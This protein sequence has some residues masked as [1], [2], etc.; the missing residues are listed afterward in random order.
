MFRRY[1]LMLVMLAVLGAG[2]YAGYY[3]IWGDAGKNETALSFVPSE[4]CIVVTGED[5]FELRQHL[6]NSSLLWQD[7]R[8]SGSE[9]LSPGFLDLGCGVHDKKN[10]T[11]P[12]A[13][14]L[15]G[16][17]R[18]NVGCLLAVVTSEPNVEVWMERWKKLN[19]SVQWKDDE[20]TSFTIQSDDNIYA[21]SIQEN[22][23][24]FSTS[25]ALLEN[26]IAQHKKGTPVTSEPGFK[27]ISAT[28]EEDAQVN[29]YFRHRT[30]LAL[31]GPLLYND[32]LSSP[33]S[34][35]DLEKSFWDVQVEPDAV[36]LNGFIFSGNEMNSALDIM[37]HQKPVE[38]R[39]LKWL[40]E[41]T[42]EF[43][44]M[45]FSS[46]AKFLDN[47]Q[48]VSGRQRVKTQ[49]DE[50]NQQYECNLER[51]LL[52]WL[53]NELM[54]FNTGD[55][56][57]LLIMEVDEVS[58]PQEELNFLS[59]QLDSTGGQNISVNN[60]VIRRLDADDIFVPLL[61]SFFSTMDQPY[62][63][64]IDN[65][66]IF[67]TSV[68][69]LTNYMN[70]ISN[71][72]RYIRNAM[73][74]DDLHHYFSSACNLLYH[75]SNTRTSKWSQWFNPFFMPLEELFPVSANITSVTCQV[76]NSGKGMY[77]SNLLLKYRQSGQTVA[78]P[79]IFEVELDTPALTRP[80][81]I[82]NH[83]TG[84]HSIM[85]QDISNKLYSISST[86][87]TE[88]K[89]KLTEPVVGDIQF[90]DI[91][92]NG[93]HQAVFA[94]TKQLH[95]ID[96]KGNYVSGFPVQIADAIT[97]TPAVMDYETNHNYRFLVACGNKIHNIDKDGKP[98]KGF[99]YEG[100]NGIINQR[101]LFLRADNKDYLFVCDNNGNIQFL[102]RKGKIRHP[103]TFS[104]SDRSEW[105]VLLEPGKTL[106]TT[107]LI[108]AN[109]FGSMI[110]VFISG[111]RDSLKGHRIDL[112]AGFG[113]NDVDGD[114][115]SDFIFSDSSQICVA[116]TDYK[117]KSTIST[118]C[119]RFLLQVY[120]P[121]TSEPVL[122][123]R[124]EEND[125]IFAFDARGNSLIRTRL[126]SDKP[127]V[128]ADL[129]NDR[130]P[131]ILY[132]YGDRLFV[133]SIK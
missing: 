73:V 124:C 41:N 66:V 76:S 120:K 43:L 111:A 22:V 69:A 119:S 46:K 81:S 63:L 8:N 84:S 64:Q 71:D 32:I 93:K 113:Y 97:A 108:Y 133:Y 9:L 104:L 115:F 31:M 12:F 116:G 60:I 100:T 79:T 107:R 80:F 110:R 85:M 82:P 52:S 131:E 132:T 118:S 51:H 101:P 95:V 20:K 30:L 15:Q 114:G 106:E 5:L 18:A 96:L 1:S 38:P 77:Y 59:Q 126:K 117:I 121:A 50:F 23:V 37:T 17:G 57:R 54:Y 49:L 127:F 91:F 68:D 36:A 45:G 92:G 47:I 14:S 112:N 6:E 56:A 62:Y 19:F 122:A 83:I 98:V 24:I 42:T 7:I 33:E 102:D 55:S 105:P 70:D 86:G 128:I 44:Y 48:V 3:L 72:R 99:A 11:L 129:N 16:E 4:A 53:D 10:N 2:V 67:S 94:T 26:A 61:G 65:I 29:I 21:G 109:K 88:W 123:G 89:I 103:V 39:I 35:S 87:R 25:E 27:K 75:K 13:W 40:P 74:Y 78:M 125:M 28:A 130:R 58:K 34:V 90:I